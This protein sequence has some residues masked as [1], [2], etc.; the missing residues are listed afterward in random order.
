MVARVML[1]KL[2]DNF[3]SVIKMSCIF[4]KIKKQAIISLHRMADERFFRD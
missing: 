2:F 1:Q 4:S 3:M